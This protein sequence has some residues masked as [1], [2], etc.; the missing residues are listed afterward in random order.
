[1]TLSTPGA[2]VLPRGRTNAGESSFRPTASTRHRPE[3]DGLRAL[4]VLPVMIIHAGFAWLPGGF[5][6]VDIFFVISG[7]LIT[8]ILQ[9]EM[10]TGDFSIVR[11]YER[12]A[13]RILPALFV[14]LLA[15]TLAASWIMLSKDFRDF[16][17]SL[18]AVALFVPNVFFAKEVGYFDPLGEYKP[19]LHTWSLGVEEQFY[20][21]YPLLLF[22]L[23]GWRRIRPAHVLA[24]LALLSFGLALYGVRAFPEANFY[25]LPGRAWELL[26]GGLLAF[27]PAE[28][29]D[30]SGGEASW[31]QDAL[32]LAGLAA[33][34]AAY[35][36]AFGSFPSPGLGA[37]LPVA[38]ALV[39]IRSALPGTM[40]YTAL[41]HPAVRSV[42][43]ISYSAYLWHQPLFTFARLHFGQVA[44]AGWWSLIG[45]TLV[46]SLLT[47]RFVE[48][49]FRSPARVGRRTIL[50]G[51]VSGLLLFA[52]IGLGIHVTN[53]APARF[54]GQSRMIDES[55]GDRSPI[56]DTCGN[57]RPRTFEGFCLYGPPSAP[58][59]AVLGD[60][61]GKEFFWRATRDLGDRPFA[62]QPFLWNA[63]APLV[64]FRHAMDAACGN[65]REQSRQYILGNPRI[66]V[67]V[68][69][70]NWSLYLDCGST[71][72]E[73]G[74]PELSR[75][76]TAG[77]VRRLSA[78]LSAEI[79]QYLAAGKK[80]VLI[81]PIP[82]MPWNVPY[83]MH[84]LAH[85]GV[86]GPH[87][88]VP[89]SVYDHQV[90]ISRAF[91][92]SQA[93]KRNVYT[94]DP[95]AA[96]CRANGGSLCVADRK[97]RPLYFDNNHLNGTGADPFAQDL[98]HLLDRL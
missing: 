83:H 27:L 49:P 94:I 51:S 87:I 76:S 56:R 75:L 18:F 23:A 82:R 85:Q 45:L 19:L 28:A 5:L 25:L 16:G 93:R 35:L 24:V 29:A 77:D 7:Y 95:S 11:F 30:S 89:R 50:L 38:G 90:R 34:I 74:S 80:V 55:L 67:V 39:L 13:R 88:G 9:R 3:I 60:S 15:T 21:L 40:V 63:C 84:A 36:G 26:A 42:G 98:L 92:A 43:L 64:A 57:V 4:A 37:I 66:R 47:W 70:A 86:A 69:I 22:A 1:M 96:L 81:Y 31:R 62:L 72:G 54:S 8:G 6:G 46:L 14:V 2:A 78:A 20:V 33:V 61:H 73:R 65:F 79:D 58:I 68:M 44:P 41:T 91:I 71:C 17:Q 97:E 32:S 52:L 59:V 53:G 48:N 10:S 12:R